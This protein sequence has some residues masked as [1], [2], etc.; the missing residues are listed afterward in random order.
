MFLVQIRIK[1]W[2]SALIA[3][4]AKAHINITFFLLSFHVLIPR[5]ITCWEVLSETKI[6]FI[7]VEKRVI[8]PFIFFIYSHPKS[9]YDWV[10][11]EYKLVMT[12]NACFAFELLFSHSAAANLLLIFCPWFVSLNPFRFH[13]FG[14]YSKRNASIALPKIACVLACLIAYFSK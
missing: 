8:S 5:N 9:E 3:S 6:G 10:Q 12:F 13:L 2:E 14:I 4:I 7:S 1:M 11:Y